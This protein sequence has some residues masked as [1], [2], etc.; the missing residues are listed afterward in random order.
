VFRKL[1]IGAAAAAIAAPAADAAVAVFPGVTYSHVLRFTPAGPISMYVITAPR[2]GGLYGIRPLLSQNTIVGRER[3]SSM[4]R[5]VSAQTTTIGVN[6]DYFNWSDGR[7][8]GVLVRGNVL[9]HHP[10]DGRPSIGIDAAGT[11]HVDSARLATSWRGSAAPASHTVDAVNDPV[12]PDQVT[13]FTPSWG[14]PT[15]PARNAVSV[16]LEPVPPTTL[17]G[18]FTAPVVGVGTGAP[19]AIPPDGV[20]L[21]GRGS[22]ARQLAAEAALG[23][24]VTLHVAVSPWWEGMRY[25]L[26]GG[27]VLVRNGRITFPVSGAFVPWQLANRHDPRTA[28]GQRAD[29]SI[30]IIA[31]DGRQPWYSIGMTYLGEAETLVRM[32]CVAGSSLDWGGSTTVALDGTVLNH[33]SDR[34]G[35]RPVAEA[36]VVTYDGVYAPFPDPLLSPNGD[37]IAEVETLSYKLVRRSTVTAQLVGP[38]GASAQLDTGVRR[39]GRYSF[40]WNGRGAPEGLW[41]WRVTATDDEGRQSA[42]K[43]SFRLDTTLGFVRARARRGRVAVVFRLG[44][45]ADVRLAVLGRFGDALRRVHAG[46]L[47]AGAHTVRFSARDGRGRRLAGAY[48]LRVTTTSAVGT[49]DLSVPLLVPR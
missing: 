36:L 48:Q 35:E 15:P 4:E 29:G 19:T 6:G 44:R 5:D 37:G 11:L 22:A 42:I 23:T 31:S 8:T 12:R 20:V 2:P 27:P 16:V 25:A 14:A 49:S 41:Q 13:L 45:A 17:G 32:G 47:D 1:L 34:G 46:A 28:I 39:P 3:V 38:G 26:G 30:V 33:P 24:Q 40:T 18:T 43:R 21:V 9:D 10:A 7:P